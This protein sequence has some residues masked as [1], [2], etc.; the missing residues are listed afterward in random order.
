MLVEGADLMQVL[1]HA[2]RSFFFKNR[3]T[4]VQFTNNEPPYIFMPNRNQSKTCMNAIKI[5]SSGVKAKLFVKPISGVDGTD[6]KDIDGNDFT[7]GF[8]GNLF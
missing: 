5:D 3:F 1:S 7:F 6:F 4:L 8:N 2:S